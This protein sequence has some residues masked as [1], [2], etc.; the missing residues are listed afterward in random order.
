MTFKI[1]AL[2]IV[3]SMTFA[4]VGSVDTP[5]VDDAQDEETKT[6][7]QAPAKAEPAPAATVKPLSGYAIAN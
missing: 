5:S 1:V 4:C 6:E 2:G 7:E 3:A